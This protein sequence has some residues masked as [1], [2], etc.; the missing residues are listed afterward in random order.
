MVWLACRKVL[1]IGLVTALTTSLSCRTQEIS[2]SCLL[3]P[4]LPNSPPLTATYVVGFPPDRVDATT[5]T[6]TGGYRGT[7]PVGGTLSLR[8]VS[9]RGDGPPAKGDTLSAVTWAVTDSSIASVTSEVNG[10]GTFTAL[11][12]G[13]LGPVYANGQ[14]H[15]DLYAC[16]STNGC[17]RV[18][19]VVLIP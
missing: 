1:M 5:T 17:A 16:D 2:G 12:A 18:S 3:G 13:S 19:E 15:Y 14:P 7:L 10:V 11:R 9:I 6:S 8:L 4:C